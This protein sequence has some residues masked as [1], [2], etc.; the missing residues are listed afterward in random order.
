MDIWMDSIQEMT[1]VGMENIICRRR[2]SNPIVARQGPVRT[3]FLHRAHLHSG[4]IAWHCTISI[5]LRGDERRWGRLLQ[6]HM[7]KL[8]ACAGVMELSGF[9]THAS[10]HSRRLGEVRIPTIRFARC[11]WRCWESVHGRT[12][13]D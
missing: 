11:D 8:P 4:W 10:A 12:D 1:E 5:I 6:S 2:K 9:A 13:D 3:A 7:G